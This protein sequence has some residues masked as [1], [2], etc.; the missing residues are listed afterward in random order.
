[1]AHAS[2]ADGPGSAETAVFSGA[3]HSLVFPV[4]MSVLT[5]KDFPLP[6]AGHG[7]SPDGST[8]SD[9]AVGSG[10]GHRVDREPASAPR[11]DHARRRGDPHARTARSW[12]GVPATWPRACTPRSPVTRPARAP[13][14]RRSG[15]RHRSGAAAHRASGPWAPG[16]AVSTPR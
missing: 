9:V 5:R 10:H 12:L 1:M 4:A 2:A 8:T 11:G 15:V 7:G 14:T 13:R 16:P 6:A 3:L